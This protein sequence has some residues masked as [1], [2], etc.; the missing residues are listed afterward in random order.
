MS[1]KITQHALYYLKQS[2]AMELEQWVSFCIV[3][4]HVSLSVMQIVCR[5][6][7]KVPDIFVRIFPTDFTINVPENKISRKTGLMG[8]ELFRT[9]GRTEIMQL[10]R[11][12]RKFA[13]AHEKLSLLMV[14]NP[15]V[16]PAHWAE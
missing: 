11:A 4:S 10:I 15:F 14:L 7:C 9:D 5:S 2:F 13:Q 8:I 6:S 3:G 16:F 12:C 1:F